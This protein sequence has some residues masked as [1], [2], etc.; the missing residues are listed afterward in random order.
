MEVEPGVEREFTLYVRPQF[1]LGNPGF[2]LLRLRSSSDVPIEL[3]SVRSGTDAVL[4]LGGGQ[5]RGP[6]CQKMRLRGRLG[7]A[8]LSRPVLGRQRV[9]EL[10]FKT[11]VFLQSTVFSA[12]LERR[13]RPGRVQRVSGGDASALVSSQTLVVVSD[14][15]ET[16]LL[17]DVRVEPVRLHPTAT[18]LTTACALSCPSTTSKGKSA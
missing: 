10:K 6:T 12:E 16:Q 4:R 7:S 17:R 15:E 1:A 11:K 3:I 9:Y 5:T 8:E 13:T 14:L 2:D 18:E